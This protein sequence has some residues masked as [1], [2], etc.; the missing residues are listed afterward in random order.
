[1]AGDAVA[2]GAV[3]AVDLGTAFEGVFA[4]AE[5]SVLGGLA[6]ETGV[7]GKVD[8]LLLEGKGL[9]GDGDGRLAEAEVEPRG[10]GDDEQAEEQ[11][12][13]KLSES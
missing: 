1:M 5:G 12:E 6:V 9:V 3:L 2:G 11:P 13:E 8:D 4:G 10:G 7:Q